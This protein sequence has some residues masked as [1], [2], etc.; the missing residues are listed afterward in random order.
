MDF[1]FYKV[2]TFIPE[3]YVEKLRENLNNIGALTIGGNYDNCMAVS[4]VIGYW[5]PLNGAKPFKGKEGNLSKEKECKV[6]FSCRCEILKE[7]FK[8][9][10]NIHP[11][12][13]PVINVVPNFIE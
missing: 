4:K 9:I 3:E 5:R 7:A 12:E 6:E 11:Y 2:E 1:K 13:T 8:V 10:K